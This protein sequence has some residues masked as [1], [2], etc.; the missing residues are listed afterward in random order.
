MDTHSSRHHIV[1]CLPHIF[2]SLFVVLSLLLAPS[3]LGFSSQASAVTSVEKEAE[4][5]EALGRLDALQTELNQIATDYDAAVI[6]HAAA[7]AKK[8]DAQNREEAARTRITELQTQLGNRASHM[9]RNGNNSFLDV[10]FGAQSFTDFITSIDLINRVNQQDA[11]LVQETKEVRAEAEAARIEYTTQEQV[12]REKQEQIEKL[13]SDK[14]V[15]A[16]ALQEEVA[17]L[18]TEMLQLRLQEELAA[19]AAKKMAANL[20]V[21]ALGEVSDSQLARI[22]A[23]NPVYPFASTQTISSGFGYRDFDASFHTGIDFSA[24]GGTPILAIGSG[25]V[26]QAG[27]GGAMGNYVMIAHGN[28]V[29][30]TYMHASALNCS[31]GQS[32]SAG[33]VI[34]YVGTT[35]NSTGN[36]LHLEITVDGPS[37][38]G[39]TWVNPMLFY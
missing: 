32:V 31:T 12:A 16:A 34:A 1:S 33:E 10:L 4:L 36:H 18:E 25:I 17:G 13:L 28:G 2:L 38:G 7:E 8:V 5:D 26:Y 20:G 24:A 37:F 11:N 30:S 6:A 3:F 27:S 14:E 22:F 35:G 29:F 19:E 23:I 9:Y 15:A 21:S 39:G